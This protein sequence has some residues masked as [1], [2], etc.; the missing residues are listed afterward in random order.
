MTPELRRLIVSRFKDGHT[1]SEIGVRFDMSTLDVEDVIRK[2]MI[3]QEKIKNPL[4]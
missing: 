1:M 2:W 3:E 4:T